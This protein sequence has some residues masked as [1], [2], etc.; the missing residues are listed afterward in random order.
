MVNATKPFVHRAKTAALG[1]L[2]SLDKERF[3]DFEYSIVN[4]LIWM[5]LNMT[6][7]YIYIFQFHTYYSRMILLREIIAALQIIDVNCPNS[8]RTV[9][10][11]IRQDYVYSLP[12]SRIYPTVLLIF[13]PS[14][15]EI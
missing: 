15:L 11:Y 10:E 14:L 2:N 13:D 4:A 8:F 7:I 3:P 1:H 9:V 5:V 12:R 6:I